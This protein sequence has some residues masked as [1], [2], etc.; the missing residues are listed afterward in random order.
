MTGTK[1]CKKVIEFE[2]RAVA[3]IDVL[4]FSPLVNSANDDS[5]YYEKLNKLIELLGSA[6]PLLDSKVSTEVPSELIPKHIYISDS[7]ILSAPLRPN[8]R[9]NYRGLSIL[10]MRAIQLTHML[11]NAGY[12]IKGGISVGKVWHSDTNIVGPAYQ[13]AYKMESSGIAPH[14]RLTDSAMKYWKETEG[15][16][17]RMSLEYRGEF[18]V[19]G[20][21]DFYI[22]S[23]SQGTAKKAFAK[24]S[25]IIEENVNGNLPEP[26]RYK[27][28]WMSQYL[29]HENQTNV[30]V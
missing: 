14:I 21:H 30:F 7:I 8:I 22:N 11:L 1:N 13:E 19:N 3:F 4:G 16:G 12:L 2:E 17:N 9:T 23:S 26:A 27:W 28:W 20:L 29:V 15:G 10:V 18:M 5:T 25:E 6:I 24:Y